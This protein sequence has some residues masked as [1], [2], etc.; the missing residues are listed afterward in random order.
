MLIL[1][2]MLP[3]EEASAPLAGAAAELLLRLDLCRAAVAADVVEPGSGLRNTILYRI[4]NDEVISEI[5]TSEENVIGIK[6]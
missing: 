4:T 2:R 3:A 1:Q 5:N 6:R